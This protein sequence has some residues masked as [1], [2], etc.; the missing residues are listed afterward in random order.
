MNHTQPCF[1]APHEL[2][3]EPQCEVCALCHETL[4]ALYEVQLN[5]NTR[6]RLKHVS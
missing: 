3:L 5:L 4:K 2:N 6:P 1:E